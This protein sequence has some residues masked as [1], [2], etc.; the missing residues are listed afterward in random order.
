MTRL[1]YERRVL[2][3]FKLRAIPYLKVVPKNDWE[4]LVL[5][6]HHGLPTRL[7]DWTTNPLVALFFAV[8][9]SYGDHDAVVFAYQ[10]NA[11]PVDFEQHTDPMNITRIELY[12]PPHISER[13]VMHHSVFTAEP[14]KFDKD[15]QEGREIDYWRVSSKAI[16]IVKRELEKIGV[17]DRTLFPGLDSICKELKAI[18]WS[19]A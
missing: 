16:P 11:P 18:D 15:H 1:D 7:L 14:I 6:Q 12:E 9:D 19:I 10:H 17:S 4:W 3:Q 8:T 2:S 5:A 13:V